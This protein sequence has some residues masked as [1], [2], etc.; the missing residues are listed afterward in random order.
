MQ[1]L[2]EQQLRRFETTVN[3]WIMVERY[4][5]FIEEVGGSIP[6]SEI[7]S[8]LDKILQGGELPPV[9]WRW[10]VSLLSQKKETTTTT[11]IKFTMK[12]A[13]HNSCLLEEEPKKAKTMKSI[14]ALQVYDSL[15]LQFLK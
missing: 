3:Y 4:P 11:T 5:A 2:M 9:L 8:L 1:L 13:L 14:W 12:M 7:S 6:G 15:Q 10:H